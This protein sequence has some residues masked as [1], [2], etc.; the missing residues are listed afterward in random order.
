MTYKAS[1]YKLTWGGI[2]LASGTFETIQPKR[3]WYKVLSSNDKTTKVEAYT[4]EH[5]ASM[6]FYNNSDSL[7]AILESEPTEESPFT[8]GHNL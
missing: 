2:E 5:T 1:D 6:E 4:N 3:L 8:I 7:K